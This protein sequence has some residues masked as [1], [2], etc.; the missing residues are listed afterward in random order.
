VHSR[1]RQLS[2]SQTKNHFVRK[3]HPILPEKSRSFKNE[4]GTRQLQ[5]GAPCGP[6]YP[7]YSSPRAHAHAAA[8]CRSYH[9]RK[10]GIKKELPDHTTK[11]S[12]FI[13]PLKTKQDEF[14]PILFTC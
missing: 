13:S 12:A 2:L 11:K 1:P 7:L 10:V 9:W 3:K 4:K 6:C 8:G 5:Q 14:S